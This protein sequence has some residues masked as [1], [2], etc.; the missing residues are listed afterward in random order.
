MAVSRPLTPSPGYLRGGYPTQ[1]RGDTMVTG[2]GGPSIAD[3]MFAVLEAC[4]A[5]RRPL[6]LVDLGELTGLPK[7]TLHRVCWK[8][9]EL[10]VLEHSDS[11]FELGARLYAPGA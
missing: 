2:D 10:R 11:G 3:R 1:R 8:L 6:T 7:T 9:V 4:A 5:S